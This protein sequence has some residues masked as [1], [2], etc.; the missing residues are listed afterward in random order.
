[1]TLI[2][3]KKREVLDIRSLFRQVL[4]SIYDLESMTSMEFDQMMESLEG[5]TKHH[6]MRQQM[7]LS[8][9]DVDNMVAIKEMLLM[10]KANSEGKYA[11]RK[12]SFK[13]KGIDYKKFHRLPEAFTPG[14]MVAG[15]QALEMHKKQNPGDYNAN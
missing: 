13:E 15:Q 5:W 7:G 8:T 10:L 4:K 14:D 6:K 11:L 1:M 3:I 12:V 9:A 2:Q